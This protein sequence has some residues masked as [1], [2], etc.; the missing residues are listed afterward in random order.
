V[1]GVITVAGK[2]ATFDRVTEKVELP[3]SCASRPQAIV[4]IYG[5][6]CLASASE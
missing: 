6:Q 5:C 3:L 1:R 4:A 2:F